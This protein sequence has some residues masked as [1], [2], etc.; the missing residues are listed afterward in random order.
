MVVVRNTTICTPSRQRTGKTVP[1]P[2][3]VCITPDNKAVSHCAI[4]FDALP[5]ASANR[6]AGAAQPCSYLM[7]GIGV[8]GAK[9]QHALQGSKGFSS[10]KVTSAL[11][12]QGNEASLA[13]S[14]D[15][16]K[17]TGQCLMSSDPWLSPAAMLCRSHS[18]P[19][20][21]MLAAKAWC[22]RG[23]GCAEVPAYCRSD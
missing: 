4:T 14:R 9:V 3:H 11:H 5:S 20:L 17:I 21:A 7:L 2:I 1:V 8:K 10:S 13:F 23:Q 16:R 22:R 6:R 19:G 18:A 15:P 12:P